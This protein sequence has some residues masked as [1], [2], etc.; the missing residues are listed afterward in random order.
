MTE[1]YIAIDT[2]ISSSLYLIDECNELYYRKC[3]G[4]STYK[5]YGS[6]DCKPVLEYDLGKCGSPKIDSKCIL[7]FS[8]ICMVL[9]SPILKF[10]I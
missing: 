9:F 6:D 8:S 1:G 7:I 5:K 3:K 4:P 10:V 2:F